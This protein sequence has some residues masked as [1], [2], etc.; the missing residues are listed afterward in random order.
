MEFLITLLTIFNSLLSPIG[1]VVDKTFTNA[2][3]K[4]SHAVEEIQVRVENVPT[5]N[6]VKGKIDGVKIATR[7]WVLR[8]NL[9]LEVFELESDSLKFDFKRIRSLNAENWREIVQSPI[10][11]GIR[12]VVT[13]A[14]FNGFL[15]SPNVKSIIAERIPTNIPFDIDL[16]QTRFEFQNGKIIIN[17]EAESRG[18]PGEVLNISLEFAL[19]VQQGH[20]LRIIEPK[21][22]FNGQ[23][24]SPPLLQGFVDNFNQQLD[25]KRLENSGI[26]A[27]LLQFEVK[28]N[29]LTVVSLIN[30]PKR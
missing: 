14:D 20:K 6:F 8:E 7:G 3:I 4:N 17:T 5:H 10:N 24:L 26:V 30:I 12:T 21:G 11:L 22:T 9:R 1:L 23:P 19:E 16:D 15:Q 13:E 28:E 27:R 25:L 18:A 2:I 29:N